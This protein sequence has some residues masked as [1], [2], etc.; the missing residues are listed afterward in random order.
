MVMT[1]T[2]A[3]YE[4]A[5]I[6]AVHSFMIL[7]HGPHVMETFEGM[8]KTKLPFQNGQIENSKSLELRQTL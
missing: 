8:K 3:Y 4:S 7:A 1:N 2:P 5:T 6:T